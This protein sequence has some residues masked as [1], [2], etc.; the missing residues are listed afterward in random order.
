[1]PVLHKRI[2]AVAALAGLLL[3]SAGS[4]SDQHGWTEHDSVYDLARQAV[5]RGEALPLPEAMRYL[6]QVAP[7]KI[8]ATH[9]EFE[10][11]RWVYEF[12]IVDPLGQL[13]KVHIDARTGELVKVSDF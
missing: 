4:R 8:V 3:L 9:Y 7:G 5:S 11:E 12:K 2:F 10:F 6:Q 13:R 1:M